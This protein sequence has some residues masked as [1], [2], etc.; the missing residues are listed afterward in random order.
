MPLTD[1]SLL[2][3]LQNMRHT[4]DYDDFLDWTQ[5]DVEPYI[6]KTEAFIKK[7]KDII[8]ARLYILV[9]RTK[10]LSRRSYNREFFCRSNSLAVQKFLAASSS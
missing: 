1:G 4:G 7:I 5:E 9:Q 10:H 8:C 3:R 6:P 2:A